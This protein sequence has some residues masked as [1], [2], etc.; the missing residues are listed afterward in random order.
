M[1]RS[2]YDYLTKL[3]FR[4]QVNVKSFMKTLTL[5]MLVIEPAQCMLNRN[6]YISRMKSGVSN[7]RAACR[8]RG[9]F[10]QPAMLFGNFEIINISVFLFIHRCLK[11]L[12]QRVN[13]FILNQLCPTQMAY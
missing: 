3:F 12:G 7:T 9:H 4:R 10:V 5:H 13:K 2:D 11:V 8:P 6:K 1:Y